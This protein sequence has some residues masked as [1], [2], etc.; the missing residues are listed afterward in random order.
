MKREGEAGVAQE[1]NQEG[2]ED[3]GWKSRGQC[4]EG[5]RGKERKL[6]RAANKWQSNSEVFRRQHVWPLLS[7]FICLKSFSVCCQYNTLWSVECPFAKHGLLFYFDSSN[8]P[9]TSSQN[10]GSWVCVSMCLG[11]C[12][13]VSCVPSRR[14]VG[15]PPFWHRKQMVM[16]RNIMEGKY[17]FNSPE[18]EDITGGCQLIGRGGG[19]FLSLRSVWGGGRG[20]RGTVWS[21]LLSF[22]SKLSVNGKKRRSGRFRISHCLGA[23]QNWLWYNGGQYDLDWILEVHK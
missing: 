11:M 23:F 1:I 5:R 15:C 2:W 8:I 12:L 22:Y 14:L 6:C 10:Q 20:V 21:M 17:S 3:S 19:V 4:I 7:N 16:I 9:L 18:W 13:F